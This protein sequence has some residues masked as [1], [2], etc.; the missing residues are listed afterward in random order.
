MQEME[1]VK[2][3]RHDDRLRK[4]FCALAHAT[5]GIDFEE[6]YQR[7]FWDERYIP[8][9]YIHQHQVVANASVNLLTLV[10]DGEKRRAIQIG[11]VMTHPDYRKQGLSSRL[12]NQIL[13]EYEGQYDI[14]YLF[15]ND[16]V[17]DFYPR[18]GFRRVEEQQFSAAI[19]PRPSTDRTGIRKLDISLP[20]DLDFATRMASLRQSVSRRFGTEDSTGIFMFYVLYVFGQDLYY[21][22]EE[23][24]LVMYQQ[25]DECLHVYDLVSSK[26]VDLQAI[27][28]KLAG[29]ETT[30]ITFHF[31]PDDEE[32][33]TERSLWDNGLF[34]KA[35][36][37]ALYPVQV[38]HPITSIA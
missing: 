6:W 29:A 1:Y 26:K 3:Y 8:H 20:Q 15:A 27:V 30:K 5:F 25:E 16:S 24:A 13:Q 4:S 11:T 12:M 17:L 23:D 19:S 34:V 36:G 14:M 7:G 9:S 10:I 33:V 21:L 38:K 2:G 18:F 22:E 35:E 32:F 28:A 31:T 37:E